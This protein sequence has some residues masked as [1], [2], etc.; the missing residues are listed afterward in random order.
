VLPLQGIGAGFDAAEEEFG[1]LGLPLVQERGEFVEPREEARQL[2]P[3]VA[4]EGV[5]VRQRPRL[6]G[7]GQVAPDQFPV[8]AEGRAAAVGE[9]PVPPVFAELV[10]EA[11]A[12]LG[13]VRRAPVLPTR[14]ALAGSVKGSGP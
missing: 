14:E 8:A 1:V 4:D 9:P 10:P 2:H 6:Q 12:G 11:R 3:Q 13:D 5:G 7:P